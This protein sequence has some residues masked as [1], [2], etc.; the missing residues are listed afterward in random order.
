MGKREERIEMEGV[1][2]ESLSNAVF[3]VILDNVV[4]DLAHNSGEITSIFFGR[5]KVTA[6]LAPD[7]QTKGRVPPKK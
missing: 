4:C 1:K 3:H 2:T 7:D 5:Y 6:E